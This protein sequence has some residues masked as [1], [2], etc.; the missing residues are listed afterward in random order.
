LTHFD[1]SIRIADRLGRREEGNAV[2]DRYIHE[3]LGRTGP[4]L[5]YTREEAAALALVPPDFQAAWPTTVAGHV[6]GLQPVS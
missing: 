5:R 6:Y 3:T 2:A 1:L 4:V